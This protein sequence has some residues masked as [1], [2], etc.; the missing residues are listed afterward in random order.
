MRELTVHY[1]PKCGRYGYYQIARNA[2][3]A[4]CDIKMVFLPIAYTEFTNL[5]R[6]TRDRLI[7]NEI[8]KNS[9]SIS[10]RILAA[11]RSCNSRQLIARLKEQLG[12]LE[13]ENK[14]LNDTIDWMH[15][16]IWDLLTRNKALERQIALIP[17]FH[18]GKEN[19]KPQYPAK[20]STSDV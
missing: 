8:L 15:Q 11:D 2:V 14:R 5:N 9:S 3:C 1:C 20:R 16:T 12:E 18:H 6:E 17:H 4:N 10:C 7:S 13:N 19:A